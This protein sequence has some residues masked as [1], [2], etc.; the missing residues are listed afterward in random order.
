MSE[1]TP[2][3][4]HALRRVVAREWRR[5][6][7][8]PVQWLLLVVFPLAAS[9]LFLAL[10]ASG[11][12]ADLPITVVDEDRSGL[13][14]E[15]TRRIDATASL[16]V[17][18]SWG[19][20]SDGARAVRTGAAYAL[21]SIPPG[22]ER[23]VLRGN[24]PTVV[25][26]YNAQYLLP[27]S[28]VRRD[29]RAAAATLA[30]E[31]E[32]EARRARGA[33]AGTVA[34]PV[35]VEA[36]TLFNPQLNYAHF[37]LPALLPAMLQIFVLLHAVG[38][39]GRELRDGTAAEWLAAAGGRPW[40]ALIGKLALPACWFFLVAVAMLVAVRIGVGT[41]V[42]GGWALILLG[43]ACLVAACQGVGTML[44][45]WTANLRLAS[46]LAAF[47]AGVAFAFVGVTFPLSGMPSIARA[48]SA[49]LPLTDYLSL[50]IEQAM[51]GA[52][53]AES[54]PELARLA[55]FVVAPFA[56]AAPRLG[57]VLREARY[58]GRL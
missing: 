17:A 56:I 50:V 37:L 42:R 39:V 34:E 9:G 35:R 46:S 21:V 20:P 22:F 7:G 32:R 1:D 14:R 57:R 41:P 58:W 38:L 43:S 49:L 26:D 15:L 2:A 8:D 52:P 45:A 24:P 3:P 51:R 23:D 19:S 29:A 28:L 25:V 27:G 4:W 54:L 47:Y 55:L 12:P 16:R 13:S 36:H 31:I 5:L 18:S 53:A 11:L 40:L 10:L 44:V 6:R 30:V 48:W 33:P